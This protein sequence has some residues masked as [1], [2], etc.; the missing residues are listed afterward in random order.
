MSSSSSSIVMQ[1]IRTSKGRS[2]MS[3]QCEKN[4]FSLLRSF[5]ALKT[6]SLFFWR[7]WIRGD[8]KTVFP[9]K[10]KGIV[11][12]FLYYHPEMAFS[13]C[14][15]GLLHILSLLFFPLR[16]ICSSLS[17]GVYGGKERKEDKKSVT[18]FIASI[19]SEKAASTIGLS[20]LSES[21]ENG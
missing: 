20:L 6:V 12:F 18:G 1:M 8:K 9:P 3:R 15:L 10:S 16:S 11:F 13:F 2:Q 21:G 14:R 17:S 7:K 19:L 4:S 5:D